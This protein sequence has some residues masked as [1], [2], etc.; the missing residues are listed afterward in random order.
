MA[1]IVPPRQRRS[2]DVV[3]RV[4]AATDR[5]VADRPFSEV[6]VG[7][8]CIEA[9]VS[10]SSLYARFPKKDDILAALFERH[11]LVARDA[12]A[13]TVAE[14]MADGADIERITRVVLAAF[15]SFVREHGPLMR[16]IFDIDPLN[17][18]YWGL[19]IEVTDRMVDLAMAAYGREDD[20]FRRAITFGARIASSSIQRALGVPM[21][22]GERLG[23]SDDELVTELASMLVAYWDRFGRDHTPELG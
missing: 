17:E 5:L 1:R 11:A 4:L 14:A 7:D 6:P 13:A 16:S 20:A 19:S 9:D 22:F 21:H 8:I 18:Q 23:I 12:A 15:I 10:M 3:E 2:R